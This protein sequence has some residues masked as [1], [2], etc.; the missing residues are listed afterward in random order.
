MIPLYDIIQEN[1]DKSAF[2]VVDLG[3][4]EE[5]YCKWTT[6]LPDITPYYAIKCNSNS[7]VL[8][9][10][11]SLGI[12]FDC[13][14]Q[15]EIQTILEIT[16]DPD[17][18]I[19]ANPCKTL[20]HLEYA[21]DHR[22]SL[23]TFDCTEELYKIHT[24]Y[25]EARLVLRLAVDDSQSVI[26]FSK[27]FGCTLENV[28]PLLKSANSLG[29][30]VVGFSFHVGSKCMEP[31]TYYRALYDTKKACDI[32][33]VM[34]NN[35]EIVDIGG[36]F[37]TLND[38]E[39]ST[40]AIRRGIRL[41]SD[42]PEIRFIAE[43]GRYF[44][45]TTHTL[46]LQI[47]GKKESVNEGLPFTPSHIVNARG[48]VTLQLESPHLGADLNRQRCIIYTLNESVYH[49]F[50]CTIFDCCVPNIRP[51]IEREP[52]LYCSRVYGYTCDSMDLLLDNVLMPNMN[53]GDWV[54]VSNFGAYTYSA[55][56][57]FN[58]FQTTQDFFYIETSKN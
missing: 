32:A 31:D 10:L 42:V 48:N 53:V 15:S 43:P 3:E 36:G 29:L 57:K 37:S 5:L 20:Q 7:R 26:K 19:F 45:E 47:I 23:M 52:D 22:V 58:G 54:Y 51:V 39:K 2:Y 30:N 35:I 9:V 24:H 55:G 38:F 27:K 28:A 14:S 4:I 11:D 13:A 44:V 40:A 1:T 21:R 49:S 18:I 16:H 33:A 41:F 56:S 50:N 6:L 34:G 17:R 25:P 8:Q 46:V 12:N